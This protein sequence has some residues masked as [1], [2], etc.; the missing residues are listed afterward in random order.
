MTGAER[1]ELAIIPIIGLGIFYLAAVFP[2][3][4]PAGRLFLAMSALILF[5]SLLRDLW[6]L[7]RQRSD[8]QTHGVSAQCMCIESTVGMTGILIGAVILGAGIGEPVSMGDWSWSILVM[9]ILS[10]GF[11]MKDF[12]F[13]WNPWRI[14]R[15]KNHLNIVFTWKK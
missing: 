5:Q 1:I 3:D 4:I 14:R 6:L 11:L 12:V 2:D 10:C 9:A 7:S 15:D 8:E 13:E